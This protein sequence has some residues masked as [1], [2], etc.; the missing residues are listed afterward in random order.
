MVD[1]VGLAGLLIA[2]SGVLGGVWAGLHIK[3]KSNCCSCFQLECV[4]KTLR[5][6]STS[7]LNTPPRTP[8]TYETKETAIH[9]DSVA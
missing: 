1:Y 4:D 3:L 7:T 9:I 6:K 5:R 2:I 8:I